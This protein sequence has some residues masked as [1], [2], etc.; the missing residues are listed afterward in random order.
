MSDY[1]GAVLDELV[2]RFEEERGDW[3]RVLAE[4]RLGAGAAGVR[5]ARTET[6]N[7]HVSRQRSLR[8]LM[9]I[10][11]VAAAISIPLVAVAASQNW[12]FFRFGD[13]PTPVTDVTVVKTGTWDGIGWQLTAYRSA[14]DGIC[15]GMTP[16]ATARSSGEGAGLACDL[17]EGVPRTPQSKPYTPHGI[18]FLSGSSEG[19]PPYI[20]GPV[21]DSAA[22]VVVHLD[23]GTVLRTPTF[24]APREL[25]SAI[26]FYAMQL[27]KPS[28]QTDPPRSPI[29]KLVGLTADG[30]I[31]A[32]L[33]DPMP[34]EGVPLSA[35]R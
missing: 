32:C 7:R 20:V 33:V 27:P 29:E 31:V 28:S 24:D 11:A 5:R 14:T 18:T 17:I 21:I 34:E 19:L 25:G 15:F 10:A 1:L 12:W 9:I 8:R 35:C 26:R 23:D 2:P 22:D 30:R 4:A 3:E 13:V 6:P 16:T